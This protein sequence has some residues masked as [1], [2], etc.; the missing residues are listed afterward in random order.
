M[1]FTLA[2]AQTILAASSLAVAL[3]TEGAARRA[4]LLKR[5]DF[6]PEKACYDWRPREREWAVISTTSH[7][8]I[9]DPALGNFD[10]EV[11]DGIGIIVD[12]SCSVLAVEPYEA[13]GGGNGF[14]ANFKG[15]K[16]ANGEYDIR[17][18]VPSMGPTWGVEDGTIQQNGED[19]EVECKGSTDNI[20]GLDVD[21]WNSCSWA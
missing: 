9:F 21:I 4:A 12:H 18:R 16:G 1:H 6:D 11:T 13:R 14:E 19:K 2:I 8:V 15:V 5:A 17:S 10:S 7:N 20:E 3:P